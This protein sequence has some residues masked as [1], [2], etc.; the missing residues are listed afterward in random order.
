[1]SRAASIIAEKAMFNLL[2]QTTLTVTCGGSLVAD[3]VRVRC[4]LLM[5]AQFEFLLDATYAIS[6]TTQLL[7][8]TERTAKPGG[9]C[10][11]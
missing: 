8:S 10:R 6:V 2:T 5:S 7:V 4:T 3:K 9:S 1:M 11:H